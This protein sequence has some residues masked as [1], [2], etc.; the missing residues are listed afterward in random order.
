[1][2]LRNK[3]ILVTGGNGFLGKHLVTK[4]KAKDPKDDH[5]YDHKPTQG[6]ID[7]AEGANRGRRLAKEARLRAA[8][9]PPVN[10]QIAHKHS[11]GYKHGFVD[12]PGK[13]NSPLDSYANPKFVDT[14]SGRKAEVMAS[15]IMLEGAIKKFND[16]GIKAKRQANR[17]KRIEKR[18]TSKSERL[19]KRADKRD[20]RNMGNTGT[21]DSNDPSYARINPY[22]PNEKVKAYNAK[23][24]KI[25]AKAGTKKTELEAKAKVMQSK[26][27]ANK[28][29]AEEKA[30]YSGMTQ[31]QIY[32]QKE[33]E[34]KNKRNYNFAFKTIQIPKT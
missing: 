19:I 15:Q 17:A 5:D 12:P 10:H 27:D 23:T 34:R 6:D 21:R 28:M 11:D 3:R 16:P 14:E 33:R 24:D 20:E 7:I 32:L 1:M 25:R 26:S 29:I 18:A 4:L 31:N 22:A 2:D 30:K 13:M 8:G 9:K